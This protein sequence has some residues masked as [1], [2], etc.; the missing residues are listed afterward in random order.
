MPTGEEKKH[1]SMENDLMK[2]KEEKY[3]LS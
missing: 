1:S 2:R 3:L